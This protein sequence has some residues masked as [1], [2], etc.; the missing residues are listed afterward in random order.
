M[1]EHAILQDGRSVLLL[2]YP[3]LMSRYKLEELLRREQ[4]NKSTSFADTLLASH[5]D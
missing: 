4:L 1:R 2:K 5:G 3:L